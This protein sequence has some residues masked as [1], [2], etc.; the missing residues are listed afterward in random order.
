MNKAEHLW[1]HYNTINEKKIN[2]VTIRLNDY[3]HFWP[4]CYIK[5]GYLSIKGTGIECA[6]QKYY[7]ES[8]KE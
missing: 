3:E 8:R 5:V 7:D 2:I 1:S 6:Y 4:Y